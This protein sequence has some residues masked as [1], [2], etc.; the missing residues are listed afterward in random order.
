MTLT[1]PS[2]GSIP[3]LHRLVPDQAL[4]RRGYRLQNL[5]LGEKLPVRT[6]QADPGREL[7]RRFRRQV[8]VRWRLQFERCRTME[9]C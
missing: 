5:H 8:L 2:S 1:S 4:A 7:A 6:A 9:P 3:L